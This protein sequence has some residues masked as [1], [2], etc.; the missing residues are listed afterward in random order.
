M[1]KVLMS[2][3]LSL[4]LVATACAAHMPKQL[5][6]TTHRTEM[7]AVVVDELLGLPVERGAICSAT[8]IGPHALLTANHCDLGATTVSVD[9]NP[10]AITERITDGYD[11][12]I[13]MVNITFGSWAKFGKMPKVGDEVWLR[14]NPDGLNQLVRH[15]IYSGII[16]E[17]SENMLRAIS[18]FD[19]NGWH[20]DSGSA[21]FD[22]HGKIIAVTSYGFSDGGFDMIGTLS[23]HFTKAQLLKASK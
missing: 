6:T 2:L 10:A 22:K 4:S 7:H 21:I 14:G 1:K 16:F 12:M 5:L 3:L 13:F 19:I 11:H 15:G 20:G 8:A 9:G 17:Q 23:L 18:M